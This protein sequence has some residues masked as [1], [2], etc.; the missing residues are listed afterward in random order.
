ML[1]RIITLSFASALVFVSCKDKNTTPE[2]VVEEEVVEVTEPETSEEFKIIEQEEVDQLNAKI[3]ADKLT[4]EE[5]ILNAYVPKDESAEGNYSYVVK[6]IS[7]DDKT[8]V[9]E[10]IEDGRMDDSIR[11]IKVIISFAKDNGTL[12]V[13]EIKKSYKCWERRG[14]QDWSSA[15]CS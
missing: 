4:S 2:T 1:K 7:S 5:A 10:L 8:T 12:K 3:E 6:T 15:Y 11:A 13:T 14:H 9:L